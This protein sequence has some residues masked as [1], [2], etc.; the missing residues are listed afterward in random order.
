AVDCLD[1]LASDRQYRRAMPLDKAME[2]VQ[3][4]SGKSFDPVVVDVLIRRCVELER[5]AQS[6]GGDK[7]KL[8]MD[9]KVERGLAPATGFA[10]SAEPEPQAGSDQPMD[11][12]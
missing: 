11:P 12:L 10:D 1:A 3:S 6:A 5:M 7:V 2:I 9:V 8:S 4:E